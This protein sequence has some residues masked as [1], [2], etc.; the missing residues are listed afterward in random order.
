MTKKGGTKENLKMSNIENGLS[1]ETIVFDNLL[2]F[3]ST[4]RHSL[5]RD[6]IIRMCLSFY[7]ESVILK[8][9]DTLCDIVG[10][11]TIR[12]RHEDRLMNELKDIMEILEKRDDEGLPLP[13]FACDTYNGMPPTSGFEVVADIMQSLVEEISNLRQEVTY[14]KETRKTET[15]YLQDITFVKEDLLSIKGELRKMNHK[16]VE[17]NVRRDSILLEH[18]DAS[19]SN[20]DGIHGKLVAKKNI[21]L[22]Y[23]DKVFS[24]PLP[25]TLNSPSGSVNSTSPSAPP[26][27]QGLLEW[28]GEAAQGADLVLPTAPPA[29]QALLEWHDET[30]YD[31]KDVASPK[32]FSEVLTQTKSNGSESISNRLKDIRQKKNQHNEKMH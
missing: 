8:S 28:N 7:K 26:A 31:D 32:L 23:F 14:L 30:V 11:K 5:K 6:D 4:A 25:E 17:N 22:E 3:V 16:L 13:K 10:V 18:L 21:H 15:D 9:K 19:T 29:S 20:A 27:S 1:G 12:R 24:S 2:C